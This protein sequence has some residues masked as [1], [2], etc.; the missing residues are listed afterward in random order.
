[1]QVSILLWEKRCSSRNHW[2]VGHK[3]AC[4]RRVQHI[5]AGL[6]ARPVQ[7]I[8]AGLQERQ[9][10]YEQCSIIYWH[11]FTEGNPVHLLFLLFYIPR[12]VAVVIFAFAKNYL[13]R[14]AYC[15]TTLLQ[16]HPV[17]LNMKKL[18]SGN[19]GKVKFRTASRAATGLTHKRH[20][21]MEN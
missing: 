3:T 14:A 13:K 17:Y 2:R 5:V 10:K 7:N 18:A 8:V 16:R 21:N 9:A 19:V 11:L 12:L 15:L 6:Y 20:R 1:M 4:Q